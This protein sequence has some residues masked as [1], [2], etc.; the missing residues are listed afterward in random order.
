M[1]MFVFI[2]ENT[3]K[4]NGRYQGNSTNNLVKYMGFVDL[5]ALAVMI[6]ELVENVRVFQVIA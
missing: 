1:V 2:A 3:S 4:I 6:Q 5:I